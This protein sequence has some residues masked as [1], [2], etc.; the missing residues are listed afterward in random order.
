[1]NAARDFSWSPRRA[2]VSC[3]VSRTVVAVNYLVNVILRRIGQDINNAILT[4]F[5]S[6]RF[7]RLVSQYT[8]RHERD[9]IRRMQRRV[10]AQDERNSAS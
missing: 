9:S 2:G 3:V 10:A 6:L 7:G 4:P 8:A 5:L 1:M